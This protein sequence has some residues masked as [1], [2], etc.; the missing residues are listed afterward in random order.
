[1]S[2]LYKAFEECCFQ[3]DYGTYTAFGIALYNEDAE[4]HL[5]LLSQF[6]DIFINRKSALNFATLCTEEQLEPIHF[7]NA[8]EDALLSSS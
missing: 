4:G 1:M 3:E 8:I 5:F 6:H 2:Y 7:Q